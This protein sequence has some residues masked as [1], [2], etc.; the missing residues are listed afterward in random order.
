MMSYV[1]NNGHP[2]EIYVSPGRW[3]EAADL[4]DHEK[5][6]EL[7]KY[8]RWSDQPPLTPRWATQMNYTDGRTGAQKSIY[9]PQGTAVRAAGLFMKE[10]W[11]ALE[12]EFEDW[13][14]HQSTFLRRFIYQACFWILSL[15]RR[16]CKLPR[17]AHKKG[18]KS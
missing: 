10:D 11:A 2:H 16:R 6:E 8:P 3:N 4:L 13:S 7:S 14:E 18:A 12:R 1:D 17:G 9:M 5:W 15:F